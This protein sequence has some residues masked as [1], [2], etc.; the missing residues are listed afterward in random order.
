M[1]RGA[2]PAFTDFNTN[3]FLSSPTGPEP[4]ISLIPGGTVTNYIIYNITNTVLVSSNGYFTNISTTNIIVQTISIT[5]NTT[6]FTFTTNLISQYSIITNLTVNYFTVNSNANIVGYIR[7]FNGLGTNTTLSQPVLVAPVYIV[8]SNGLPIAFSFLDADNSTKLGGWDTNRGGFWGDGAGLTNIQVS[9]I[10]GSF[11]A[12]LNGQGTN[13]TL[14]NTA[15]GATSINWDNGNTALYLNRSV[16]NISSVQMGIRSGTLV[17]DYHDNGPGGVDSLE[18]SRNGNSVFAND[19]NSARIYDPSN[20]IAL[21]LKEQ[22]DT[23]EWALFAGKITAFGFTNLNAQPSQYANYD[24]NTNLTSTLNGAS[25]TNLTYRYTTNA[26]A[27]A[28]IQWG[29]AIFTNIAANFT[30]SIAAPANAF[31]ETAILWVTNS[32]STDFNVTMP[33]GVWGPPGSGTPP[34]FYCTNKMLTTILLQHY[35]QMMTNAI[36]QDYAP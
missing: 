8:S 34:V 16:G 21:T 1:A 9:G 7:D 32:S 18:L 5:T 26:L 29:Q 6:F 12:N 14:W 22:A 23:T 31:Y 36:K 4:K 17:F 11:I 24:A 28:T 33:N 13:V 20:N 27:A 2:N 35:G 10:A 25:W 19:N 3:Q 15:S 30:A